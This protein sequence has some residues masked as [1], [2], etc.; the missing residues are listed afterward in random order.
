MAYKIK[1]DLAVQRALFIG[2]MTTTQRQSLTLATPGA[3][4]YDV[5][6]NK[7]MVWNGTNW[8]QFAVDTTKITVVAP[9]VND[10]ST[11]GYGVSDLWIDMSQDDAY[12]CTDSTAGAA[13]WEK[14]TP[15][16]RHFVPNSSV[17]PAVAG[18]PTTAEIKAAAGSVKDTLVLY[19]GTDTPTDIPTHVWHVDKIGNFTLIQKPVPVAQ[20]ANITLTS[21]NIAIDVTLTSDNTKATLDLA[22]TGGTIGVPTGAG[23]GATLEFHIY[24]SDGLKHFAFFDAS[25]FFDRSRR[26][27]VD[28]FII[29]PN[30]HLHLKFEQVDVDTWILL[31]PPQTYYVNTPLDVVNYAATSLDH[32]FIRSTGDIV[33][34]YFG[35]SYGN[36]SDYSIADQGPLNTTTLP[37]PAVDANLTPGFDMYMN[38]YM[39]ITSAAP[40]SLTINAPSAPMGD[41]SFIGGI[42]RIIIENSDTASH[43]VNFASGVYVDENGNDVGSITIGA[44]SGP[45]APTRRVFNFQ[46]TIEGGNPVYRLMGSVGA[47][48]SGPGALIPVPVSAT[49]TSTIHTREILSNT[50]N[51]ARTLPVATGS[52]DVIEFALADNNTG[53]KTVAP[54][55]GDALNGSTATYTLAEAGAT[56]R[57]TDVAPN[58]WI[59]GLLTDMRKKRQ[60]DYLL[61]YAQ[62]TGLYTNY[63]IPFIK[64]TERGVIMTDQYSITLQ[65]NR[66]YLVFAQFNMYNVV[67][68]SVIRLYSNGVYDYSYDNSVTMYNVTNTSYNGRISGNTFT[69][70]IRPSARVTYNFRIYN[71]D[72]GPQYIDRYGS[73]LV[74]AEIPDFIED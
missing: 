60:T 25:A 28:F 17:N 29:Q 23:V 44:A 41:G 6:L 37:A 47:V 56:Y 14:I 27:P 39:K 65:A 22:H 18:E 73:Y 30:T 40:A 8:E 62:Q 4:V 5:D 9:T 50:G 64:V 58:R 24:S 19:N 71:Q 55:T 16:M 70:I 31:T 69:K 68:Y 1:G 35:G 61:A 11:A 10:D 12:I 46:E 57:A 67:G 20:P 7:V 43:T 33:T 34:P 53:I 72:G 32:F 48:S 45:S 38:A 13:V 51:I 74:V 42:R 59:I 66:L 15:S 21:S 52:G 49:G 54:S 26:H 3:L 63:A 36:V 2:S